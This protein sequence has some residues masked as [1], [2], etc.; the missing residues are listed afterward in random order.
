[1][2]KYRTLDQH[3]KWQGEY[4]PHGTEVTVTGD[5][6]KTWDRLVDMKV[7]EKVVTKKKAPSKEPPPDAESPSPDK[8]TPPGA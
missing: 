8:P 3:V 6:T 4:I 7:A 5:D 2:A 1:M